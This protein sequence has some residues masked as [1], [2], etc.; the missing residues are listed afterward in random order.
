MDKASLTLLSQILIAGGVL[1]VGSLPFIEQYQTR[2]ADRQSALQQRYYEIRRSID[3]ATT[4]WE[5]S[6]LFFPHQAVLGTIGA[7]R[8]A[9]EEN[10]ENSRYCISA[11][12]TFAGNAAF[13]FA[14]TNE[15]VEVAR[16]EIDRKNR[17][18]ERTVE[19]LRETYREHLKLGHER[20]DQFIR[21]IRALK[22]SISTA[23]VLKTS[24]NVIGLILN[25]VGL[26][27]GIRASMM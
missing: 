26:T 3:S 24:L 11:A 5:L 13:G 12:A 25:I 22:S 2:K 16:R 27:I 18:E 8:K 1:V 6:R 10:W 23:R 9:I 15:E 20:G 19:R 14:E 4:M 7:D 21:E 17:P